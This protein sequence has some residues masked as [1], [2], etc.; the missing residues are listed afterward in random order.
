MRAFLATNTDRLVTTDYVIDELLTL[1]RARGRRQ[2]AAEFGKELLS[3]AL[4]QLEW[5]KH[6]DVTRA[7]EVYE[8][9]DDKDWSFTD[10]VSYAVIERL[11]IEKAFTL[12]DHFRQFG[13]V[14]VVP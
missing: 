2:R 11:G 13:T 10:C 6:V 3:G 7:L 9:F 4:A 1:L 14:T 8:E 12:D 5:A